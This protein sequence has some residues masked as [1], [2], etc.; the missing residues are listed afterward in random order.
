VLEKTPFNEKRSEFLNIY[1]SCFA[2]CSVQRYSVDEIGW[3]Y[4]EYEF[5]Q[6]FPKNSEEF[7]ESAVAMANGGGGTVYIGVDDHGVITGVTNLRT[8][9]SIYNSLRELCEPGIQPEIRRVQLHDKPVILVQIKEGANKPYLVKN[10]GVYVRY[11]STDRIAT[12]DE[13]DAFY[14]N[15]QGLVPDTGIWRQRRRILS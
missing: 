13:L 14:S 15:Q 11:G 4:I 12:R 10:K 2:I 7:V 6:E 9:D 1:C 5:K 3:F 8:E